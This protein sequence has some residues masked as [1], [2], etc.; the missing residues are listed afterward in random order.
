MAAIAS[1]QAYAWSNSEGEEDWGPTCF[2]EQSH[3]TGRVM[4]MTG[5]DGFVPAMYVSNTSYPTAGETFSVKFTMKDGRSFERSG[6]VDDYFGEVYVALNETVIRRL[7][8]AQS[9]TIA[10][11]DVSISVPMGAP[12]AFDKFVSCANG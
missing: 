12:D 3:K 8:L 10:Y 4:I 6:S 7:K 11:N 9:M 2:L 5:K 1:S